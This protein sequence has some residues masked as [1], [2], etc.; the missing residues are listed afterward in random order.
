MQDTSPVQQIAPAKINLTLH[1]TGQ[2]QDGY[3]LLDSLVVFA[4]MGDRLT[5]TRGDGSLTL[6]GPLAAGVP[7]DARNL[8]MKAMEFAGLT[9][10]VH[11][12]KHLPAAAGIGGG[13]SDAAATLRGLAQIHGTDLPR[14]THRLGADIPVC[15]IGRAA[16][17]Q[18]IGDIVTPLAPLPALHGVLINPRVEVPTP[19]VFKALT[20]RD[21]PPMP[22]LPE[23][24]DTRTLID[25]LKT[26]RNDLEAPAIAIAPIIGTVLERLSQ[27]PDCR[28]ARMSGSGATCFGLS[29]TRDAAEAMAQRLA[30]PEWWVQPVSFR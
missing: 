26:T 12:E 30:Y 1:V 27:D 2:R 13:S 25:W 23:G 9:A 7:T 24:P 8:V 16:R 17:M 18:G 10:D 6:S 28:L 19:S 3:H 5:L 20:R 21:N 22:D 15:L 14:D 29:E 4:D 11:L